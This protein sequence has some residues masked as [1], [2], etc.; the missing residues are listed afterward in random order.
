MQRRKSNRGPAAADDNRAA[1]VEA[2]REVFRAQGFHAPLS[3]IAKKAGVGQGVLYRHFPTRL[4]IAFAAFEANWAVLD[5]LAEDPAPDA[6]ARVWRFLIEKTIHELAFIEMVIDARRTLADFDGAARLHAILAPTLARAQAAGLIDGAL[7]VDDVIAVHRLVFGMVLTSNGDPDIAQQV[8]R[9]LAVA[10]R[11][12][13]LAERPCAERR[14]NATG[15]CER[16]DV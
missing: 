16:S 9:A 7:T 4:A 6:F 1:L 2:A 15:A 14:A 11:L 12:P 8:T 5:E 10:H 3:A 13:P